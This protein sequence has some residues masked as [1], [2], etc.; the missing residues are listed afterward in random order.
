MDYLWNEGAGDSTSKQHIT[1]HL[2]KAVASGTVTKN[3]L[4]AALKHDVLPGVVGAV[5]ATLLARGLVT[6]KEMRELTKQ[7]RSTPPPSFVEVLRKFGTAKIVRARLY[8]EN[9]SHIGTVAEA[10][11]TRFEAETFHVYMV[12]ETKGSDGKQRFFKIEKNEVAE[13]H[14]IDGFPQVPREDWQAIPDVKQMSLAEAVI[15]AA[16]ARGE[17]I[18]R[19]DAVGGNCQDFA[20]L[21]MKSMR[22]KP[23]EPL[24]PF[25]RPGEVHVPPATRNFMRGI[26]DAAATGARLTGALRDAY[27]RFRDP[28]MNEL[29]SDWHSFRP[30]EE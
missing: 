27:A 21:L 10:L 28:T 2:T 9:L 26:T 24:R 25:Y 14:E 3:D 23:D 1:D 8:R 22:Q 12:I 4:V 19:Y 17:E 30:F 15:K 16:Q 6:V 20:E 7:W 18:W 11:G 29:P 5:Y 13:L